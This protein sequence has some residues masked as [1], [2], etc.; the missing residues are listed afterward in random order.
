MNNLKNMRSASQTRSTRSGSRSFLGS[1]RSSTSTS[2]SGSRSRSAS[3]R[4]SFNL[5]DSVDNYSFTG[6]QAPEKR[7]AFDN[8]EERNLEKELEKTFWIKFREN[9]VDNDNAWIKLFLFA[10]FISAIVILAI[11][12]TICGLFFSSFRLI[13]S[14][15]DDFNPVLAIYGYYRSYLKQKRYAMGAY[16]ALYIYAELYQILTTLI[17]LYTR[18]VYHLVS[19][20][21]FLAAMA[22]YAGIQ[23]NEINTTI[24]SFAAYNQLFTSTSDAFGSGTAAAKVHIKSLSI[25]VIIL[26]S[27]ICVIQFGIGFRLKDKFQKFTGETIGNN[28]KMIYANTVFNLHR[29]ALLLALFFAPGYFLQA[30]VI[31]PNKS[32]AEFGLTLAALFL[33]VFV[34]FGADY[35]T[36]REKKLT[37]TIFSMCCTIGLGFIIFKIVRVYLRYHST[38]QDLPGRQSVVAFGAITSVLLLCLMVLLFLVIKNFGMGL[39]DIYAGNYNWLTRAHRG[40]RRNNDTG[41]SKVV[42]AEPGQINE[43]SNDMI[44]PGE[45][46]PDLRLSTMPKRDELEF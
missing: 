18:N 13:E 27:L 8:P 31:A 38:Y 10:S 26:A 5:R 2:R 21:L 41:Y 28:R 3:N 42:S 43:G 34:I 25:A 15:S 19:S 23:Y 6:L 20:I 36:S 11:E 30:V 7:M 45:L 1:G 17:V 46:S 4:G 29:D 14:K 16:L 9:V 39:F 40:H 35:S 33:S 37:S 22:I 44:T 12:C 32:D 24:T